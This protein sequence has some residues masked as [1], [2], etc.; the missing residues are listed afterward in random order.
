[1]EADLQRFYGID[2]RDRWRTGEN[3]RP[4][5]TLRRLEVLL[6]HLPA[7]SALVAAVLPDAPWSRTERLMADLWQ[8]LDRKHREHPMLRAS[9]K[10]LSTVKH[11]TMT[12]EQRQ[13][14]DN[15][16]KAFAERRRR[17]TK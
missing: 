4:L 13:R 1:M 9:R 8:Q 7:E 12:P 6:E 17:L 5:L 2:Y 15:V 11:K 14:A 3:G 16:R 10:K